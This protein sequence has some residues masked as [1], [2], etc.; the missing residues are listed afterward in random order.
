[1]TDRERERLRRAQ[2]IARYVAGASFEDVAK[3]F[4]IE[5]KTAKLYWYKIRNGSFTATSRPG[6][7]AK[8][9]PLLM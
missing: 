3:E 2:I 1:M 4:C 9:D 6:R 5:P 7:W 8:V